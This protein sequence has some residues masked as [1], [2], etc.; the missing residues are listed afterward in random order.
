MDTITAL[1]IS[2]PSTKSSSPALQPSPALPHPDTQALPS[3]RALPAVQYHPLPVDGSPP[4]LPSGIRVFS[5]CYKSSQLLTHILLQSRSNDER[6]TRLKMKRGMHCSRLTG[7]FAPC[8]PPPFLCPRFSLPLCHSH[9]RPAPSHPFHVPR[10]EPWI[11]GRRG[12]SLIVFDPRQS[13]LHS[14]F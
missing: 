12:R 10:H 3:R 1:V 4:H 13:H 14:F 8:P 9:C 6:V 5:S 7:S 11:A 2:F